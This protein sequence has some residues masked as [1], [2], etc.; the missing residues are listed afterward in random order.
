[1]ILPAMEARTPQMYFI[2]RTTQGSNSIAT[3]ANNRCNPEPGFNALNGNDFLKGQS[4]GK[5]AGNRLL[6]VR[7]LEFWCWNAPQMGANG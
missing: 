7:F 4:V 1:M 3:T 2:R 5:G 6:R